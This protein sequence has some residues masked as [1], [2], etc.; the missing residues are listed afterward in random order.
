MSSLRDRA[1]TLLERL[2]ASQILL[3]EWEISLWIRLGYP[4]AS[5][6]SLFL[7]VPDDQLQAVRDLAAGVGLSPATESVLRPAYPRPTTTQTRLSPMSWTGITRGELV[8]IAEDASHKYLLIPSFIQTVPLSVACAALV[9]IAIR[10]NHGSRL[11]I[12]VIES[13]LA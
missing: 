8:S 9:R 13:L 7:L 12:N 2:D 3:V 4:L 10:E 5:D 1:T 6:G 11:R